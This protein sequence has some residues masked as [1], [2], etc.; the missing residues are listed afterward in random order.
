MQKPLTQ[1]SYTEITWTKHWLVPLGAVSSR[2]G[3]GYAAFLPTKAISCPLCILSLPFW[4]SSETGYCWFFPLCSAHPYRTETP[5][6]TAL[7]SSSTDLFNPVEI[8]YGTAICFS[9][10]RTNDQNRRCSKISRAEKSKGCGN[11]SL[12]YQ[13]LLTDVQFNKGIATPL[14]CQGGDRW[15]K[16]TEGSP[17]SLPQPRGLPC[18]P[19]TATAAR[20]QC[21][22]RIYPSRE[23]HR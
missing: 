16:E 19:A 2:T 12:C 17:L 21:L 1:A 13:G 15:D 3:R 6:V 9:N 14:C 7:E 18:H 8:K 4:A 20:L 23:C 22:Q 11:N 10:C 5:A